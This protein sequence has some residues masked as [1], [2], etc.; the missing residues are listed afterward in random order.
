MIQPVEKGVSVE[1][2]TRW[3]Q[4]PDD[5]PSLPVDEASISI[6]G[7]KVYLTFGEHIPPD[8]AR[9][10]TMP[11]DIPIRQT[12]RLAM[13]METFGKVALL[14]AR[15]QAAMTAAQSGEKR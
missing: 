10:P 14:L 4:A 13:T 9:G 2:K 1:L 12:L 8:P 6:F 15:T 5:L 11:T 3:L 7:D